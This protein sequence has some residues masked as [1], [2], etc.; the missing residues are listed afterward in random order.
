[1]TALN[2]S[3]RTLIQTS[4]AA[5]GGMIVGYF[6]PNDMRVLNPY[7]TSWPARGPG[8]G[9]EINAWLTIDAAGGVTVLCPYGEVGQGALTSVALMVAEE[10]DVPWQNVGVDFADANRHLARGKEYRSMS[11][12]ASRTVRKWHPYIM[13]A[14]ASARERL[15][16]AA[17]DAWDVSRE[18]V[19]AKQG[20]LTASGN[21]ASYGEFATAAAMVSLRR[22]PSLKPP[23]SW[24]LLGKG[25]PRIDVKQKIDGSAI[26]PM[27]VRLPGM[28]YAAA[29]ACPV[30]GGMLKGYDFE[31]VKDLPGV[32]TAVELKQSES[33]PRSGG[34]CSG[35]A[36]VAD[37]F[38][39][40]QTA[41]ERMPIE[42]DFGEG[43]K[44]SDASFIADARRLLDGPAKNA[45]DIRGDADAEIGK[46]QNLISA[47]YSRPYEFTVP[48]SP[49]A[50]VADVKPGRIDL[51]VFTKDP[52]L[53]LRRAADQAGM[54][55]SR[56]F[57]HGTFQGGSFGSGRRIDITRQAVE[58]SKQVGRPVKI[59]WTREEEIRRAKARPLAWGRFEAVLG[60]DGLPSALRIRAIGS[61]YSRKSTMR[62]LANIAYQIPNIR[63]EHAF[64]RSNILTGTNRAP[65]YNNNTFM[66]EQFV[67]ELALA[68][69]WNPLDWRIKMTEGNERWQRVLLKLKEIS[70]FSLDLPSGT[71][72]GIAAVQ[73]HDSA[74]A[75]CAHVEV[76]RDG[77]LRLGKMT[78]VVN[79]GY[80]I[81]PRAAEEQVKGCISW[82]L[83]YALRGGLNVEGG[84]I[85]N[86]NFDTYR[87]LRLPEMPPVE[88]V[89]AMSEDGWWG[90]IGECGVP[91]VAP[92]VANAVYFAT[93]KRMR[94][95]PFEQHELAWA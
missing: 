23:S 35:V 33:D 21:S 84:A 52:P 83:G 69:G 22:E 4:V 50:A 31:A 34:L 56:V 32:I 87:P 5:G 85:Q 14:G 53:E 65:G 75:A 27:D 13:Q 55:P 26:Y 37:N 12:G 51:W 92:A 25:V 94:T 6:M 54:N 8:D 88:C 41:L 28:V 30:R 1:M 60:S 62:G 59:L 20:R 58:I 24:W 7:S 90:G 16:Q 11:I 46:A 63:I 48:M 74:I 17:A 39:R 10:L 76:S 15:R 72:M 67:D 68:G 44:F 3:R 57:V 66:M 49:P 61:K 79:S 47:E 9:V 38:W 29:C 2:I 70:G 18:D 73:I 78:V 93:G 91:I 45:E 89:F 81:N 71:G 19:V 36:I 77:E 82:E 42:W 86:V 43:A 40:A 80:V 64:V 95:T